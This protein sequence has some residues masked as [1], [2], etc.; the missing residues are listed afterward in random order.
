M[1][2]DLKKITEAL[3]AAG[4]QVVRNRRGHWEVYTADGE[5]VTTFSGT[6]SDHRSILNAP[7]SAEAAGVRVA[8]Q[9]VAT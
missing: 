4:Y 9:T 6:A 7:R 5:K 2:K 1:D 8:A 3:K